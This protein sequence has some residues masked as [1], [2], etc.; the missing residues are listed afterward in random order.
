[1]KKDAFLA[2][3]CAL[4]LGAAAQVSPSAS[5]VSG[6]TDGPRFIVI[7]DTHFGNHEGEGPM[8]KVPQ[9]LRHLLSRQPDADA[10][11]ICGDLTDWG[12]PQQYKLFRQ[13]FSDTTI[14]PARLPVYVMMGNHDNY[15]DH[16]QENYRVLQQPY[17]R[18]IDIK[19]YPFITTSMDGGG[20][21][22]YASEEVQ[23]LAE[24]LQT[25][26]ARYPGKPIFV[27]THVPPMNTV[28]G[29]CEGEGGWGSNVLTETLKAYPQVV[30]FGGHSHFP[31]AD[32]RSIHQGH[33]TTVNDG[34]TTY[35]EIE[36]GVVNEGIHPAL[37]DYVTEGCIVT[38]DPQTNVEIQR[39]D[40]YGNEEILP[41]WYV[42]APHDG[43]QFVY[44]DARTGGTAPQWAAGS[45]PTVTDVAREGCTVTFPQAGDDENVHHYVVELLDNGEAVATNSVF[46]GYY[47]NSRMP[48][49]LSVRFEGIPDGC[50]LQA[51]VRAYDSYKNVSAPIVSAPFETPVYRPAE[52]TERPTA[53]LF[54]LRFDKKGRATDR[55]PHRADVRTGQ[56]APAA[57]YDETFDRRG[58]SFSGSADCFYRIDYADDAAIRQAFSQGFTYEVLYRPA[59]TDNVCPL[60]AQE[61]GG[62]GIEQAKDGLIQFYCHVGGGYKTL[63]S[64]VTARAGQ[65]YHVVAVYDPEAGQ[66]RLYVNGR[67]SGQMEVSGDFGFPA[68][69][70]AQWIGIGGDANPGGRAQFSLKGDILA[71]RMYSRPVSRDEVYLLY[72]DLLKP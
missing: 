70:K 37:Y 23:A 62:A 39:W 63:K 27:F 25:A 36:P 56:Q 9:A 13:V 40:T 51:S 7:S 69:A 32:P 24:N 5:A 66:L 3:A 52:G 33:F 30:L 31:L 35:S 6:D 48:R 42:R 2:L 34:S 20:W 14:V 26:A 16:A 45:T 18:L 55:S 28:Y 22:D 53:D 19:G 50:K 57:V 54:D 49:T 11:F 64:A 72:H 29:T 41:R 4:S 65:W 68:D 17:H 12:L 60:S 58:A 1:M 46:S 43:S 44:T 71:A 47:L 10:I 8:V 59:T 61:G 21:D 15:A 67:P 38:V